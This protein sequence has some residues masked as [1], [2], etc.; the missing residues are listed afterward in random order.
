MKSIRLYTVFVFLLL[1]SCFYHAEAQE[2]R[3]IF[4]PEGLIEIG[5]EAFSDDTSISAVVIPAGVSISSSAFSGCTN[6]K[7]LIVLDG[8]TVSFEAV[9]SSLPIENV[10]CMPGSQA[11][12]Y[13]GPKGIN[14]YPL[15]DY[16][17]GGEFQTEIHG[18]GVV[19]TG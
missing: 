12:V 11:E 9:F 15:S 3:V 19:I 5:D 16:T 6:L 4:P 13:F 10:Y 2:N 1:F 17:S 8:A 7:T 14:V 18:A